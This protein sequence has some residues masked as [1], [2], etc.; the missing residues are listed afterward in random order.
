MLKELGI[1]V[2][3]YVASEICGDSI[4]VGMIKHQGKIEY[5]NDVR[6]ITRKTVSTISR[7]K[8]HSHTVVFALVNY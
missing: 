6:T 8:F 5:V 3:R 2:E 1:K 7:H 4:A